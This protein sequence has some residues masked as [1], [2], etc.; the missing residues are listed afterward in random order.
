MAVLVP[1]VSCDVVVYL[2][3]SDRAAGGWHWLLLVGCWPGLARRALT[4]VV[5]ATYASHASGS[6]HASMLANPTQLHQPHL[7]SGRGIIA[8][9]LARR[10]AFSTQ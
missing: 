1:T 8:A 2:L 3:A 5:F 6:R 4:P 9:D 7:L 10:R